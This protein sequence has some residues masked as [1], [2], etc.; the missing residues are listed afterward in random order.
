LAF[1]L[2]RKDTGRAT[3]DAAVQQWQQQP[4]F[5]T[6]VTAAHFY[7]NGTSSFCY[8]NGDICIFSFEI[9]LNRTVTDPMSALSFT[10]KQ[11]GDS[12]KLIKIL[13]VERK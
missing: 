3:G 4:L 10:S 13:R 12:K 6:M 7:N 9:V 2:P 8:N 1:L 5:T 11:T